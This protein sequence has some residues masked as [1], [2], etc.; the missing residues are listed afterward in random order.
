MENGE[1]YK[2]YSDTTR[3]MC[4]SVATE[5]KSMINVVVKLV[6]N[7]VQLQRSMYSADTLQADSHHEVSFYKR[8]HASA[9]VASDRIKLEGDVLQSKKMLEI[10]DNEILKSKKEVKDKVIKISELEEKI[11]GLTEELQGWEQK[12]DREEKERQLAL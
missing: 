3:E 10:K 4:E 6:D 7:C 9:E 1:S 12:K 2:W 5:I 8:Y 11:E